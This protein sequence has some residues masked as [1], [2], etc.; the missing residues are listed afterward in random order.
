M[1]KKL[2]VLFLVATLFYSCE[3]E[4]SIEACIV[5]M[6]ER[7][8]DELDC[9]KTSDGAIISSLNL[10]R[11]AYKGKKIYWVSPVCINCMVAPPR[12]GYTCKGEKV[13][14]KD[15]SDVKQIDL[16]HRNNCSLQ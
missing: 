16:V 8:K 15:Y 5:N 1:M 9:N 3:T 7:F 14:I 4:N 11:G 2:L 6:Q 12:Y 10:Y 13:D